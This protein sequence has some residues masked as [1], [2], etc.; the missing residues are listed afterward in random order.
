M[1]IRVL[2]AR[3]FEVRSLGLNAAMSVVKTHQPLA[4]RGMQRQAVPDAVRSFNRYSDLAHL[5]LYQKTLFVLNLNIAIQVE[6]IA[7]SV[8]LACL[9]IH[10]KEYHGLICFSLEWIAVV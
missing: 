8:I 7:Q 10:V 4:V 6:Q 1:V 9:R 5:H 2:V 3:V